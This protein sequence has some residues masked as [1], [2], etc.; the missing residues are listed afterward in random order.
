M[1]ALNRDRRVRR[2]V[3]DAQRASA[4]GSLSSA[5]LTAKL[6]A[7]T[8][9][10]V[11]VEQRRAELERVQSVA[12][13][14]PNGPG[15]REFLI[16]AI[17]ASDARW[18]EDAVLRLADELAQR[19]GPHHVRGLH[20]A[21]G[22]RRV[23]AVMSGDGEAL[24][25]LHGEAAALAGRSGNRVMVASERQVAANVALLDGDLETADR[26]RD[27]ALVIGGDASPDMIRGN[28][29]FMTATPVGSVVISS[30]R[31][32]SSS[33]FDTPSAAPTSERS[34]RGSTPHVAVATKRGR[35]WR[36]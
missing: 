30:R 25:R 13:A 36:G 27:E 24:R 33:R 1:W 14:E 19:C 20:E 34:G 35:S 7:L 31:K 2:L 18:P 23:A 16:D 21:V 29:A 4:A 6:A 22:A 5:R 28:H 10:S 15:V 32:S 9:F 12:L 11:P 8:A 26:L 17:W 3:A